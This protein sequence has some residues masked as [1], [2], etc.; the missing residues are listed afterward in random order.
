[1]FL[2]ALVSASLCG[3]QQY[4]FR[5]YGHEDGLQSLAVTSLVQ[6]HTGYIWT[7]TETWLL[8]YDGT[9]F[10]AFDADT[11]LP[12]PCQ[13][14][15]LAVAH[16]NALWA[17]TCGK[18]ARG[19]SGRFSVVPAAFK[20]EVTGTQSL[21]DDGHGNMYVATTKGLWI[22]SPPNSPSAT[23]PP[24][25]RPAFSQGDAPVYGLYFD[26]N[27]TFWFGCGNGLCELRNGIVTTWGTE[28]GLTAGH[29]AAI[30]MDRSGN[31]WVR[32]GEHLFVRKQN[33]PR[34][35][36][37]DA[38]LPASGRPAL[39]LDWAGRLLVP[40]DDGLQ[41]QLGDGWEQIDNHKG[42]L[43]NDICCVLNDHEGSLW[44][45]SAGAGLSRLAGHGEWEAW[46]DGDGLPDNSIWA[47]EGSG[48]GTLWLG[49]NKGLTE[50][51]TIH[52]TSRTW[53]SVTP[54]HSKR[55]F[56]VARE[57]DG[58]IWSDG[59]MGSTLTHLY[60]KDGRIFRYDLE[61]PS[62]N[63]RLEEV[64]IDHTGQI[65]ACGRKAIYRSRSTKPGKVHF[66]R[67][68]PSQFQATG[69]VTITDDT[70]GN[71]WVTSNKG[72][73]RWDGSAWSLFTTKD[74]L[75]DNET[76]NVAAAADG[77][78][79]VSYWRPLGISH[80]RF[81]SG[82]HHAEHF[83]VAD[84]LIGN[85]TNFLGIDRNGWVW[86]G[87]DSGISVRRNGKWDQITTADGLAW[88]D[89]N[90]NAFHVD[91]NGVWIGTSRGL[92]RFRPVKY[93]PKPPPVIITS[94]AGQQR[95]LQISFSSLSFQNEAAARF[96]YRLLPENMHWEE[97]S[98]RDLVFA[99]LSP[100][101]Y[102][103][104]VKARSANGL[105]SEQPA[106]AT[107]TIRPF[108]W[109]TTW[110]RVSAGAIL[111]FFLWLGLRYRMRR[112]VRERNRLEIAVH[113][114][115]KDLEAERV[116]AEEA[117]KAKSQFLAN[118]SHEIRT[119]MNGIIGMTELALYTDLTPEQED[120][121]QTVKA[122]A[123]S[124]LTILNDVLDFSKIEAGKLRLEEVEF[125]IAEMLSAALAT[126]KPLAAEK[127]LALSFFVSEGVPEVAVG[128]PIRLR[129]VLINLLGN[130]IKF[131]KEGSVRLDLELQAREESQIT[132][133]FSVTDTG[134]GIAPEKRDLIFEAFSQADGSTTRLYGGTGLGLAICV[135]LVALMNG[136]IWVESAGIGHGS[137]FIFTADLALG[138][139]DQ[140]LSVVESLGHGGSEG[141]RALLP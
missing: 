133:K 41:R 109:E 82:T 132:L 121:L 7:G 66:E 130:A 8:R 48:N 20:I 15:A 102:T 105:W 33:S 28:S 19:V 99:N 87:S 91:D 1:M 13:I 60:P 100:G 64:L 45:G 115:T 54:A 96:V 97:T 89:C 140:M 27:G 52:H 62:S 46:L 59:Q 128:D 80:M 5:H 111:A 35:V 56:G 42:L 55:V 95:S 6:D 116:K 90:R 103:F 10:R 98:Q 76:Y 75:L 63:N 74:G 85:D 84:G 139:S 68:D 34:F 22:A 122:S 61:P 119:P 106:T 83:T 114:R 78:V 29:W 44:I 2:L 3:A 134:I 71:I 17:A 32:S 138:R 9:R 123:L 30:Q 69:F 58:S 18:L 125:S 26:P 72:L 67:V 12:G 70:A 129:Q 94:M 93:Q 16:D 92:A 136:Q 53:P 88:D 79:W 86:Q 43:E 65:W 4:R 112:L 127:P 49:S 104:E 77:S 107:F 73:L 21:A 108:W 25:R 120:Y 11:G 124:L 101:T 141:L 81:S 36:P 24:L 31:L 131:T 47:I 51:D 110:F 40:T 37:H 39:G 14:D 38:K 117:S 23:L 135:H 118:M 113:E 126:V 57:A 50:L 137:S